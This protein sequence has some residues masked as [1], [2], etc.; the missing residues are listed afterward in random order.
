MTLKDTARVYR[1][2]SYGG[3][4]K[5]QLVEEKV[6]APGPG[7][8]RVQ[9]EALSLNQSDLFF[10]A[11]QYIEQPKLPSRLGYEICGIVD[12]VGVGCSF[13]PGDRVSSVPGFSVAEHGNFG[14]FAIIPQRGVMET[15]SNLEKI[16]A[17]SFAFAYF[18]NYYALYELAFLKPFSTVLVTAAT[19]TTG[20]AAI[21]MIKTAGA[22]VIAT[23]RTSSKRD[24]LMKAGA[25]HVIATEEEDLVE[26][27]KELTGGI[28]CDI[29]YDCIAGALSEKIVGSLR[30]NG[31]WIVYGLMDP[32]PSPFPW[33]QTITK[34]IKIDVYRVFDFPGNPNLGLLWN[35][36]ALARGKDYV[37]KGVGSGK[38]LSRSIRYSRDW[39]S[40]H[41]PCRT[42]RRELER[43][44]LLLSFERFNVCSRLVQRRV[45]QSR[46]KMSQYPRAAI[47]VSIGKEATSA[48]LTSIQVYKPM[49][50]FKYH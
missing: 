48:L 2:D 4:D 8:V 24:L 14:E 23:T 34:P 18:T 42:C 16:D 31:H 11:N 1:F 26:R 7:Q 25:S 43:G 21:A 32:T 12:A 39:I 30:P 29:A 5:F 15:P 19:S 37:A 22:A 6:P 10:L 20:L 38:C 3:P 9:V 49:L 27:V 40:S 33:M 41:K 28:G 45:A 46:C 47:L 36:A 44:R 50:F 13:K 35:D 17:A